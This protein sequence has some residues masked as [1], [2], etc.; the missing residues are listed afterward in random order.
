MIEHDYRLNIFTT[1][2]SLED[3]IVIRLSE[4]ITTIYIVQ[5]RGNDRYKH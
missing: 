3:V 2:S 1:S 5:I 4:L